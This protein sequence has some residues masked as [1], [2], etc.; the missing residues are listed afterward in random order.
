[1]KH[2]LLS[3]IGVWFVVNLACG[4]IF[5]V[6]TLQ[7]NGLPNKRVNLVILGDGYTASEMAKFSADARKLTQELF[8]QRPFS[9][10]R[11]YF[12]VFAIKV[13]SNQSGASHP[14][15][16]TDV[17]E[18]A[19]PVS[20][21]DNYFG[22]TFDFARIHRLLVATRTSAIT[23]V[24]ATNFPLYDQVFILVNS[25][26]YG[27]SGGVYAVASTNVSSS[28]IAIHEIGHSFASLAD[29]YWAGEQYARETFNMTRETNPATVRWK[30][31]YNTE[32][33][34]IFSYCC[35]GSSGQ[36]RRPHENCKMRFLGNDFCA[37]CRE[38]LIERI[39]A[40]TSPI[41][42]FFPENQEVVSA[43][44]DVLHFEL[45]LVKPEPNTLKV[46]WSVNGELLPTQHTERLSLPTEQLQPGR[47]TLRARVE[48]TSNMVRVDNHG[49]LHYDVI[50]WEL[51]KT[52]THTRTIETSTFSIELHAF[53]NPVSEQLQIRLRCD[54]P[55]DVQG[56]LHDAQGRALRRLPAQH[57]LAGMHT[58]YLLVND[59]PEGIYFL[60][61]LVNNIP[62][63]TTIVKN[64]G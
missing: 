53:P 20:Q 29:E 12:N 9:N 64:K 60:N 52:L 17:S 40:L 62:I 50:S 54:V 31:W 42:A 32:M 61:V 22:S 34:G 23:N 39:H 25:P 58:I 6:D 8:Q 43:K 45:A 33:V 56:A 21:V 28:E 7:Y 48:D 46:N 36:W 16:A 27:G 5:P 10:Y 11:N 14:G 37:V 30:N 51:D 38:A 2:Y 4:Q 55:F 1:M 13:P 19:H 41:D 59:L 35:G 44:N 18:P 49:A 57:F 3:I 26:Y 15:N 24:L 63:G 47:N